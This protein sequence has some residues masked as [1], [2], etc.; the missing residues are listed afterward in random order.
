LA[1]R[2]AVA[3]RLKPEIFLRRGEQQSGSRFIPR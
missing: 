3:R 2:A 1:L